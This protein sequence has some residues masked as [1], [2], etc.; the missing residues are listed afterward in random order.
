MFSAELVGGLVV[1][2][3][4]E[5]RQGCVS[6]VIHPGSAKHLHDVLT[7]IGHEGPPHLQIL[8]PALLGLGHACHRKLCVRAKA[9][10][11][12]LGAL[13]VLHTGTE[14]SAALASAATLNKILT[15]NTDR[16][17]FVT[18]EHRYLT[19]AQQPG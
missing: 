2:V 6:D 14:G 19:V 15:G 17:G 18:N 8:A 3:L 10:Q 11:H 13:D 16:R 4:G 9:S 5:S 12:E 1:H 7:G